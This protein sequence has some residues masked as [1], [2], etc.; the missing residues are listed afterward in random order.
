MSKHPTDITERDLRAFAGAAPGG[1]HTWFALQ[2]TDLVS[3]DEQDATESDV[4]PTEQI[5]EGVE[6][7][8]TEVAADLLAR[9]HEKEPVF[10]EQ[11]VVRLLVAMGYGGVDGQARVTQ[12]TRDGG[13]DG[14]IDQD[15][16]GLSR[17]FVQAKRY[18]VDLSVQ[19]PELQA[20]VGALS[21][22]ADTGVFITTGRFSQGAK[23][24]VDRVPTRVIL[25]DGKQLARLMIKY[26][27]GVQVRQHVE[28]VDVDEDFFE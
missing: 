21:G 2:T 23:D 8:N 9:L 11:A 17:V 5:L 4:D 20:F 14:I 12:Q 13:I 27:V 25:I 1:G 28:I 15:P 16:L 22:K 26:G 19:R 3:V 7:I 6:R 18:A 24:Y 10:F